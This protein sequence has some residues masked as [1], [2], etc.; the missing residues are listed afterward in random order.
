MDD[1]MEGVGKRN[2]RRRVEVMSNVHEFHPSSFHE[3]VLGFFT[4]IQMRFQHV[5]ETGVWVSVS[6]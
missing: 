6:V 4:Y 2:C 1:T 3:M 5:S